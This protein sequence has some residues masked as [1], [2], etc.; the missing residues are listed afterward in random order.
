MARQGDCF[1]LLLMGTAPHQI[2][3]DFLSDPVSFRA[4]AIACPFYQID[5][6][7]GGHYHNIS[8]RPTHEFQGQVEKAIGRPIRPSYAFLRYATKGTKLNHLIHADNGLA[9][10][11]CVLYLNTPDQCAG[12]TAFYRHKT[13]GWDRV[14]LADE[15]RRLGKSPKRAW[16]ILEKSWND[17]GQWEQTGGCPMKFN[18]AVIFPTRF[19]HS[20]LPLDG[21]GTDMNDARLV[22][23][24]FFNA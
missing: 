19:F 6:P 14:M 2:V 9:E 10:F 15:C 7:D 3:D 18:R 13:L 17:A 23:V 12:G 5:G 8:M 20:R 4:E 22:Y 24:L 16:E 21:F 11:G 1:I